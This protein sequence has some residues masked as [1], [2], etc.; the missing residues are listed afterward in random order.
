MGPS[1]LAGASGCS[2][3]LQAI[4]LANPRDLDKYLRCALRHDVKTAQ[5]EVLTWKIRCLSCR[6]KG[7]AWSL[8][9][10]LLVA[11]APF[12]LFMYF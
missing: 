7:M 3:W 8:M 1:A 5:A 9:L 10:S 11:M 2:P 4:A 6:R 12:R